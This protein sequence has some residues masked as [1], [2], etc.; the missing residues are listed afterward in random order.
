MAKKLLVCNGSDCRKHKADCKRLRK[1]LGDDAKI[2]EVGCQKICKGVVAG[3]KVDGS[4][5][6]FRKLDPKKDS[7][8]LRELM[9][10]GSLSKKLAE[11]RVKKRAGRLR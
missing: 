6:W 5:E 4:L 9:L 11:K 2:E 1:S 8:P 3:L 7:E 10:E